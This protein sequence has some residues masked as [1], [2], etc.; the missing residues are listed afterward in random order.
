M[1]P[2]ELVE[3]GRTGF[4]ARTDVDFARAVG[5]LASD[6]EKRRRMG[7]NARLFAE[8][9]SWG[10]IFAQLLEYYERVLAQRRRAGR[11][12]AGV[13]Q[14][15]RPLPSQAGAS[16][17]LARSRWSRSRSLC[18]LDITEFFGET[19]GG[20]KTGSTPGRGSSAQPRRTSWSWARVRPRSG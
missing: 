11:I 14:L 13:V 10:A 15:A 20:V 17:P 9:R 1:G 2:K 19:S 4:V 7:A 8:T 6:A 16:T 12:S 5:E 3:P 18:V